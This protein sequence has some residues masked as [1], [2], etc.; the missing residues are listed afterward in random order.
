MATELQQLK[1]N[2]EDG[3]S[4]IE[5]YE[6]VDLAQMQLEGDHVVARQIATVLEFVA[7]IN[8]AAGVE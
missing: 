4:C 2:I 1:E 6:K 3:D 5:A 8:E 7:E